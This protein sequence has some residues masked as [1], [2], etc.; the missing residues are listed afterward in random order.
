MIIILKALH[1]RDLGRDSVTMVLYS[2]GDGLVDSKSDRFVFHITF[3]LRDS[4]N[5]CSDTTVDVSQFEGRSQSNVPTLQM[6]L[7]PPR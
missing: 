5:R 3:V 7:A 2:E 1:D 6:C 4:V